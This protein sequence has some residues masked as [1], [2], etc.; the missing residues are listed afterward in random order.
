MSDT[1]Q[2]DESW[3]EPSEPEAEPD[4]RPVVVLKV[5]DNPRGVRRAKTLLIENSQK[6]ECPASDKVFRRGGVGARSIVHLSR[7]QLSA[8]DQTARPGETV[9]RDDDYHVADDLVIQVADQFWF[10]DLTERVIEFVK[11]DED[12][13]PYPAEPTAKFLQTIPSVITKV[14]F[15][16]LK[17][18]TETPTLRADHSLLS[19]PGYDR[20]S[21]LYYE[22]GRA[23]FPEIP[24]KPTKADASRMLELF[25]GE[26]GILQDF[27]FTDAPTEPKGLSLA[28]ALAMLL[29]S[30][31]RR[32]LRTAPM[33]AIDAYEAQSGKTLL[34]HVAGAMATGREIAVR[35]WQTDEYQRTNALAMAL[36]AGDP[37]LLFDNLGSE[38]PLTG[39]CFN[40]VLTS[41]MWTTRR[42]GSN[43][44]K[45]ALVVP[46]NALMIGT[47]NHMVI[48]GDMTEGRVL[49]TRII[50]DRALWQRKFL[51]RDLLKHVL[52]NRPQFVAA[53]LTIL[54][55]YAVAADKREPSTFRHHEWAD[56]VAASVAWLGLPDPCLAEQR[57]KVTDPVREVQENVVRAWAKDFGAE[58]V[59]VQTL[60]KAPNVA[61]LIAGHVNVTVDRLTFKNATPFLRD[62]IGIP[63]LGF[64]VE[65]MAGDGN[66]RPARWRLAAAHPGSTDRHKEFSA[67]G[68]AIADFKDDPVEQD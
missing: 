33:F 59:E 20:K 22:P 44:G 57:A 47:G 5:G 2:T 18:T 37:V 10:G 50:P 7:N 19:T 16:P 31:S 23:V 42:L 66:H 24:D 17:G 15:P 60:I 39:D 58:W 51:Y 12:G 26:R 65:Q 30:V 55:G 8:D 63:R 56:L 1:D 54:R 6:P 61:E 67:I 21:G 3:L 32:A 36:E 35:P 28:V 68:E 64:K 41:P 53:A 62:L 45:D 27:P 14:D 49:V 9:A 40:Q 34:G 46:T 25:T 48:G 29:T 13:E 43:S 52:D 4:K 38:A 11:L